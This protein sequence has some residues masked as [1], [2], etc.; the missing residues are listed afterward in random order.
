MI[1][2][3]DALRMM[4][5]GKRLPH[6]KFGRIPETVSGEL[7]EI[8]PDL[9][10]GAYQALK[11]DADPVAAICTRLDAACDQYGWYPAC[12]TLSMILAHRYTP[13]DVPDLPALEGDTGVLLKIFA[14]AASRETDDKGAWTIPMAMLASMGDA[15][16]RVFTC[17]A[18][19]VAACT[20]LLEAEA[21]AADE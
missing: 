19:F 3:S 17:C 14:I 13:D 12:S 4:G 18:A 21:A 20:I 11:D 16:A 7:L 10:N 2:V 5:D 15:Q 8:E 9:L 1:T 6:Q